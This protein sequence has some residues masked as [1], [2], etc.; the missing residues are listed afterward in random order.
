MSQPPNQPPNGQYP[1]GQP[2]GPE[3]QG[4]FPDG[5]QPYGAPQGQPTPYDAPQGQPTPQGEPGQYGPPQGQPA[6]APQGGPQQYGPVPGQPPFDPSQ[7]YGQQPYG[8]APVEKKSKL[9]WLKIAIPVLVL[10]IGGFLAF[11]NFQNTADVA[12]GNCL[13]ISGDDAEDVSHEKVDCDD[14]DQVSM[15]VVST[16]D[17]TGQCDPIATEYTISGRG[18]SVEKVACLLPNF[19]V[20][21]CYT[22]ALGGTL[23]EKAECGPEA[24]FKVTAIEDSATF[25]CGADEI[26]LNYSDPARTI[27]LGD[28]TL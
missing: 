15:E 16:H 4:Q 17:E 26:P 21:N 23:F 22:T 9:G 8:A 13:A 7:Q 6:G 2:G 1:G 19:V 28:P 20:D 25:E 10:A 5:S 18:G 14:E 3:G 24:E 27:C 11:Q 12:V